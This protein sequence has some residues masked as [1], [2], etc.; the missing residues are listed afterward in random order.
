MKAIII[1]ALGWVG[2]CVAAGVTAGHSL[3]H[4]RRV[5]L[6][7]LCGPLGNPQCLQRRAQSPCL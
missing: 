2:G 7:S 1:P 6:E 4:S 5:D 3:V